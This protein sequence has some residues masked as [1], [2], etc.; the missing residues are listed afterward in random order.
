MLS[1]LSSLYQ[2]LWLQHPAGT[3]Q[4][5][6]DTNSPP[7]NLIFNEVS[8]ISGMIETFKTKLIESDNVDKLVI[9]GIVK[10]MGM[11]IPR[12]D[13]VYILDIDYNGETVSEVKNGEKESDC[14]NM[15]DTCSHRKFMGNKTRK[16]PTQGNNV[17]TR[18]TGRIEKFLN[19]SPLGPES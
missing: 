4:K 7:F 11:N 18:T 5:V 9:N 8:G 10:I 1:F 13:E 19:S 17:R 16:Q 15:M 3:V 14:V 12:P 2:P 6:D